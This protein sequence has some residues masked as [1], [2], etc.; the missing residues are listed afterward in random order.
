MSL[1]DQVYLKWTMKIRL[2][3]YFI[4]CNNNNDYCNNK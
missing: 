1:I 3:A 2:V 4:H